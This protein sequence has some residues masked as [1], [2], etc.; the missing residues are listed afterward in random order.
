MLGRWRSQSMNTSPLPLQDRC[1][2]KPT[3]NLSS[4]IQMPRGLG[5]EPCSY[6]RS[7]G[8][9]G[10]WSLHF[11]KNF[12][13]LHTLGKDQRQGPIHSKP[14]PSRDTHDSRSPFSTARPR[15]TVNLSKVGKR[16]LMA[17]PVVAE[18]EIFVPRI[19]NLFPIYL[20]QGLRIYFHYRWE[21]Q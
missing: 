20:C 17:C 12:H 10:W 1:S 13:H 8:E 16:H 19:K 9:S 2:A 6:P 5:W 21:N 3:R 4:L 11:N 7:A 18:L 15:T 14:L